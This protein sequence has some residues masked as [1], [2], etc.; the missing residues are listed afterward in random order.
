[1]KQVLGCVTLILISC[2]CF[3][4]KPANAIFLEYG[5]PGLVS[6]NYDSRFSK[7]Q[8]GFGARIG[9]GA[10][11]IAFEESRTL[12]VPMAINYVVGKETSHHLELGAGVSIAVPLF[13][14]PTKSFKW[15]NTFGHLNIGYRYQPVKNGVFFRAALNPAFSKDYFTPFHFGL[16]LGYKF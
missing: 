12:L 13:I 3:S 1:M 16:A 10:P 2:I 11:F 7:G 5:G 4:Q 14:V 8:N 15:N 9:I 6:I